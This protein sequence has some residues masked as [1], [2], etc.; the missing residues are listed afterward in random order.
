MPR[1][2][3]QRSLAKGFGHVIHNLGKR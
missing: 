1:R 2:K 3:R